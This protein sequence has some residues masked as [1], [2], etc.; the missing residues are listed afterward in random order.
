MRLPS[1]PLGIFLV[2][3]AVLLPAGAGLTAPVWLMVMG[4]RLD[5]AASIGARIVGGTALACA[6]LGLL[7]RLVL[8]PRLAA[9]APPAPLDGGGGDSAVAADP[10]RDRLVHALVWCLFLLPFVLIVVSFIVGQV[11]K[12]VGAD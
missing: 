2:I 9:L 6:G 7:Y 3:C 5:V 10:G 8:Q 11:D 4:V 1:S 12:A